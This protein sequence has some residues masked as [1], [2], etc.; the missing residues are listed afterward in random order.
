[1]NQK[2]KVTAPKHDELGS[3]TRTNMV[4]VENGLPHTLSSEL[5]RHVGA[6]AHVCTHP[7]TK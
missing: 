6:E 3:L 7:C 2:V 4:E 1:M 5:L